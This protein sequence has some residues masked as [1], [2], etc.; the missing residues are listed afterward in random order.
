MNTFNKV[1]G[2]ALKCTNQA[3]TQIANTNGV[4]VGGNSITSSNVVVVGSVDIGN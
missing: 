2:L 3:N 1:V 4:D